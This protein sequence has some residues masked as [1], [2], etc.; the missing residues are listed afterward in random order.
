MD[1]VRQRLIDAVIARMSNILTANTYTNED[2][3]F[4][5]QTNIGE[6]VHDWETNFQEDELPALSV[7]DL[8]D[9]VAM[10]TDSIAQLNSLKILLR[11][12]KAKD[13]KAAYLRKV[14]GDIYAAIGTDS[15]WKV[16]NVGLAIGTVIRSSGIIIPEDVFE[17]GGAAVEIEIFYK[18]K[19]FN[20]F[21][22]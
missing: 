5:Y 8:T 22:S 11:V 6:S 12:F 7:C 4:N 3:T 16:E 18:S 17:I 9:D 14:F 21:K 20:A 2:G 19:A 10:N 15:R 1:T 13:T